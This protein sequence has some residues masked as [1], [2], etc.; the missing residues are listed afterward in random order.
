MAY[1][2]LLR[3]PRPLQII[4]DLAGPDGAPRRVEGRVAGFGRDGPEHFVEMAPAGGRQ[5]ERLPLADVRRAVRRGIEVD[6][7]RVILSRT[8][9]AAFRAG[10]RVRIRSSWH[11]QEILRKHA[12]AALVFAAFLLL[13][14]LMWWFTGQEAAVILTLI[15]GVAVGAVGL[16]LLLIPPV[17]RRWA[18]LRLR[19]G[20]W[21]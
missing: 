11:P 3:F 5:A 20:L 15:G 19:F 1:R 12:V 7:R 14:Y 9:R 17:W 10:R 6:L 2:T 8:E 16:L 13:G 4:L 21:F 18:D